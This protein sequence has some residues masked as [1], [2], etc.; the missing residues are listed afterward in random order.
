MKPTRP[1]RRSAIAA[2]SEALPGE[3]R[4]LG[5]QAG[6][7]PREWLETDGLGGSASG[8]AL[9]L[10]TRRYHSLLTVARGIPSDRFVLVNGIE[11]WLSVAG[12]GFPLTS[13]AYLPDTI[14]GRGLQQTE[15]FSWEPWPRWRLRLPDGRRVEHEL[16]MRS[17]F[18]GVCLSFRVESPRPGSLLHV[19]P[20]LSGRGPHALQRENPRFDFHGDPSL[21]RVIYRPYRGV[22]E[23]AVWSN[24]QYRQDPLWYR[25]F[26]YEQEQ[27]RGL[28]FVEDLASP[29]VFTFNLAFDQG[30]AVLFF[31]L[32]G[33]AAAT[34][35]SGRGPRDRYHI[36]RAEELALRGAL[37]PERRAAHA[38]IVA[39]GRG[40]TIVA[41]Y[42]WFTDWGRDTFISLRGLCL[43]VGEWDRAKQILLTWGRMLSQGML[44]NCF[45]D[46]SGPPEYNSVDSAL[47]FILAVQS[48]LGTLPKGETGF[49]GNERD[50]LLLVVDA[51]VRAFRAGTRHGIRCGEDGLLAAGAPGLALTWMDARVGGVPVTQRAGKPVEVQALWLN[52]LHWAKERHTDVGPLLE[53]GLRSFTERFWFDK[54]GYLHDVVDVDGVAG[55]VDESLRPNQIFAVGGLPLQLLS[56][57]RARSVVDTVERELWTPAGLRSLWQGD[58]R[59]RGRYGGGPEERDRAYHQGTAWPWLLGA[60]VEAWLRVHGDDARARDEARE[61][62]QLPLHAQLGSA[63]LGHLPEIADGDAP[64][65]PRGCPFQ[66]WSFGEY[67]RI[68]ALLEKA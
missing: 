7:T 11:A 56:G 46:G 48:L 32:E 63:G 31:A 42:P 64:H 52:A 30:E 50:Q 27:A 41:G 28:D 25:D 9:G 4:E 8:T 49:S 13:Q 20:L 10:R 1:A 67:L 59:Y 43:A 68:E 65:T 61:R 21:G 62:F 37:G 26:K 2:A 54:G 12:E 36:Y 58:A 66:A 19:R 14:V 38:Y 33:E 24:G 29:G 45:P 40:E 22:P 15:L 16:F 47:W 34:E 35:F 60:F 3:L 51:I 17:G 44:P 18:P 55:T 5:P 39:R 57:E 53:R 6:L 23:L